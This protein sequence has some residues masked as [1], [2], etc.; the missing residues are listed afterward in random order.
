MGTGL[1]LNAAHRNA[2]R[3]LEAELVELGVR[4]DAAAEM[5]RS[6]APRI[7][8]APGGELRTFCKDGR[9]VASPD[10]KSPL[11]RLAKELYRDAPESA[12]VP[13][14]EL[15]PAGRRNPLADWW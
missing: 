3:T 14:D 11:R 10:P 12:K 13:Q 9:T 6:A 7:L 2:V 15:Q 8:V 4:P 1:N 5:A